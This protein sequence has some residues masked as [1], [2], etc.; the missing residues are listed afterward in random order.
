MSVP[1]STD[2]VT[3]AGWT[4]GV[5]VLRWLASVALDDLLAL[6]ALLLPPLRTITPTAIAANAPTAMR[7]PRTM[8]PQE[9]RG[10]SR[11]GAPGRGAPGRGWPGPGG[12]PCPAPDPRAGRPPPP[13]PTR[14]GAA[15]GRAV[16]VGGA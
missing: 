7:A 10:G 2:T 1:L 5:V 8:R 9:R 6:E 3:V 12:R 11:S 4:G 16:P 14:G 13:A 15:T